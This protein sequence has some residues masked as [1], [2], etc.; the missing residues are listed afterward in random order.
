LH[1]AWLVPLPPAAAAAWVLPQARVERFLALLGA[2]VARCCVAALVAA[3]VWR[4][5]FAA[6]KTQLVGACELLEAWQKE[7]EGLMQ[8][9]AAAAGGSAEGLSVHVAA[10]ESV[11]RSWQ[12]RAWADAAAVALHA[13]LAHAFEI[14]E[15]AETLRSLSFDGG[16]RATSAAVAAAL[17]PFAALKPHAFVTGP[18]AAAAWRGAVGEFDRRTAALEVLATGQLRERLN[19]VLLPALAAADGNVAH[20]GVPEGSCEASLPPAAQALSELRALCPLLVRPSVA[21]ALQPE[22]AA[23]VAGIDQLL[24]RL[25][26]ELDERR[27]S[28]AEL[29]AGRLA[30]SAEED[31][32]GGGGD[33]DGGSSGGTTILSREFL[34]AVSGRVFPSCLD[35]RTRF[36]AITPKQTLLYQTKQPSPISSRGRRSAAKRRPLR[37]PSWRRSQARPKA[38]ARRR[39]KAAAA[40]T[41]KQLQLPRSERSPP[42]RGRQ[43]PA[44]ATP[45]P[46]GKTRPR[47]GSPAAAQAG[48]QGAF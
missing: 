42:W 10:P 39:I 22:R 44:R 38:A 17:A 6:A 2:A 18:G 30:G 26:A 29:A 34:R 43:Q 7:V 12:G 23:L 27:G 47:A 3:D 28:A 36:F 9:W 5:P 48:G 35:M 8:S 40:T 14:Q 19:S 15:V 11:E 31:K 46:R 24:G 21:A 32:D 45:S 41:L 25:Q 20:N 13:R 16:D 4:A 1:A 37:R 33:A